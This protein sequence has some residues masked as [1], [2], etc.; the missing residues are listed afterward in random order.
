[1]W[2][3]RLRRARSCVIALVADQFSA[4]GLWQALTASQTVAAQ[5]DGTATEIVLKVAR[6]SH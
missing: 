1:M 2:E 5:P 6:V 3:L 4:P